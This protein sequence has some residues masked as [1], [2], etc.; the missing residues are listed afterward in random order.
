MD[1]SNYPQSLVRKK[2]KYNMSK[3]KIKSYR[4]LVKNGGSY[5]VNIPP[6]LMEKL[7]LLNAVILE[8]KEDSI[9]IRK[10]SEK[11]AKKYKKITKVK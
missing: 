6:L 1:F 5:S 11:E 7:K 10:P 2:P 3:N 4:K 8:E 9:I